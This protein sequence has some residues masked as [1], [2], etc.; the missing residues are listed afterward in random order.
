MIK[1]VFLWLAAIALI[2]G[3]ALVVQFARLGAQSRS[4]TSPGLAAGRLGRCPS[5]PNCVC[6]EYADDSS[7]YAAAIPLPS[8]T[9]ADPLEVAARVVEAMGGTVVS[10]DG[11]YLAAT[12]RSR[13]FG[14]VDD[15][16]LRLDEEPPILHF[17]SSSRVGYG[18]F[19]VN[20]ARVRRFKR[21]LAESL[22]AQ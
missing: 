4:G 10:N 17:R 20:A 12:F 8:D 9:R 15:F 19:G 22:S 16:E 6:S 14:F 21:L 2:L 18:D 11:A 5:S 13:L 7:H 3:V 1:K